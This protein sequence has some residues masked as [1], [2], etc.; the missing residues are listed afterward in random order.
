MYCTTSI[1][2]QADGTFDEARAILQAAIN[3]IAELLRESHAAV[4][5]PGID[6]EL[7]EEDVEELPETDADLAEQCGLTVEDFNADMAAKSQDAR[8]QP[9]H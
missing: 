9:G 4:T 3:D 6:E 1:K 8:E 7:D 5:A 2:L